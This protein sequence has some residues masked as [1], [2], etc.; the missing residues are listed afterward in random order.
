M[1]YV[2][3]GLHYVTGK[4]FTVW[5][6][7]YE[8]LCWKHEN[9]MLCLVNCMYNM[10]WMA[11]RMINNMK[12]NPDISMNDMISDMRNGRH[13]EGYKTFIHANHR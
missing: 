13:I 6:A 2:M 12:Y 11:W 7:R 10:I 8:A 4:V 5:I 3:L 9:V 1:W